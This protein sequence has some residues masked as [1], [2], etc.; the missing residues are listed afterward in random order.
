MAKEDSNVISRE[1]GG[2]VRGATDGF[3]WGT[4][5]ADWLAGGGLKSLFTG[6]DNSKEIAEQK[7]LTRK[8]YDETWGAHAGYYAGL[9]ASGG[10][11]YKGSKAAAKWLGPKVFPKI[12]A[13]LHEQ[14]VIYL[15]KLLG[16]LKI[17]YPPRQKILE[18]MSLKDLAKDP[19]GFLKHWKSRADDLK[20]IAEDKKVDWLD[21][22]SKGL[23][24]SSE[25]IKDF[26]YIGF[27]VR[28]P[29]VTLG[30]GAAAAWASDK[31]APYVKKAGEVLHPPAGLPPDLPGEI[32]DRKRRSEAIQQLQPFAGSEM[33]V[34]DLKDIAKFTPSIKYPTELYQTLANKGLLNWGNNLIGD[35]RFVLKKDLEA[36]EDFDSRERGDRTKKIPK[37]T[38][39][40]TRDASGHTY[41]VVDKDAAGR[42]N[43][44]N[45]VGKG[46]SVKITA[47]TRD[48]VPKD[49]SFERD[50]RSTN[51][52]EI[53]KIS[54]NFPFQG[55]KSRVGSDGQ[56]LIKT[57]Q[58]KIHIALHDNNKVITHVASLGEFK[59]A[60]F[61]E[62]DAKVRAGREP[63]TP[64]VIDTPIKGTV[65]KPA[66]P[67]TAP[68]KAE[69]RY[70]TNDEIKNLP[71]ETM[72]VIARALRPQETPKTAAD[73]QHMYGKLRERLSTGVDGAVSPQQK[74]LFFQHDQWK[75][76]IKKNPEKVYKDGK[77]GDIPPQRNT[78]SAS[79]NLSSPSAA[80]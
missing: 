73:K 1:I 31:V 55:D 62:A 58:A 18:N 24:R 42:D 2:L 23:Q 46:L 69:P 12:A 13:K 4:G 77:R 16:G 9:L 27:P 66:L 8:A 6:R 37:A 20:K 35:G 11:L 33:E 40:V 25:A 38:A 5:A 3:T 56:P 64:P 70:L 29:W 65:P 36:R 48:G 59:S 7:D 68:A 15:E 21:S 78:K 43:D 45:T 26:K 22:R 32:G 52:V 49:F 61:F 17:N 67:A 79:N 75:E 41:L 44:K 39:Y 60:P 50:P 34:V 28:H 63:G 51:R 14:D 76:Y 72:E 19:K 10:I 74:T 47:D 54:P 57:S 71:D 30:I 53:F 80:I